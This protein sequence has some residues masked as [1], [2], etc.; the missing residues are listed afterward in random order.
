[1]L[2]SSDR[3][4]EEKDHFFD[5]EY[6]DSV[7]EEEDEDESFFET[8]EFEAQVLNVTFNAYHVVFAGQNTSS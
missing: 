8:L 7:D 3:P 4:D 1:M 5:D 6:E 2:K